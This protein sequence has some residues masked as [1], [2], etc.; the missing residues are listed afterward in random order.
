MRL[1]CL[2]FF[3]S[4]RLGKCAFLFERFTS[5]ARTPILSDIIFNFHSYRQCAAVYNLE[6]RK[7]SRLPDIFCLFC[8]LTSK[9]PDTLVLVAYNCSFFRWIFFFSIKFLQISTIYCSLQSRSSQEG[10]SSRRC[11]HVFTFCQRE[12]PAG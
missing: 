10:P 5:L 9:A 6:A 4:T 12:H 7:Q 1:Q 3:S 2:Q 8:F 11:L